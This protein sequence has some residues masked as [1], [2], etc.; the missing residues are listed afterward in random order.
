MMMLNVDDDEQ[1]HNHIPLARAFTKPKT[2]KKMRR[3]KKKKNRLYFNEF[4]KG[5]EKTNAESRRE[6]EK[7]KKRPATIK[8]PK[9]FLT[10]RIHV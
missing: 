1:P 10:K 3:M 2:P 8:S 5:K 7:Q 9:K 4:I 6:R